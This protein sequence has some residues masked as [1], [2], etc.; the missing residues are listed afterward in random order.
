MQ[1]S[2]LPLNKL[3]L[4]AVAE[5]RFHTPT[6]VQQKAIPLILDKKNVIVSAQTGTGKTA[7]FALPILHLLSQKQIENSPKK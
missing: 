3:I 1:F 7:A 6:L 5:A 4:K 2:N